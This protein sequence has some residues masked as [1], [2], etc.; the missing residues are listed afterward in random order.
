MERS[1]ESLG[2]FERILKSI[3]GTDK[4]ESILALIP[5]SI[6]LPM[7]YKDELVYC[8]SED[9][10]VRILDVRWKNGSYIYYFLDKGNKVYAYEDDLEYNI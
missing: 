5:D 2:G 3:I 8:K 10:D 7:F 4:I 6:I 1:N 9:L